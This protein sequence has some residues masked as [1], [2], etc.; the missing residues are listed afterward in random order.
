MEAL[1]S[2]V[3]LLPRRVRRHDKLMYLTVALAMQLQNLLEQSVGMLQILNRVSRLR[4]PPCLKVKDLISFLVQAIC[5]VVLQSNVAG[6]LHN[7]T[8]CQLGASFEVVLL[9]VSFAQEHLDVQITRLLGQA[10]LVQLNRLIES[11]LKRQDMSLV[12]QSIQAN[13]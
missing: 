5:Q 7:Q 1:M 10:D 8:L 6:V 4:Y 11:I 12:Q 9:K 3:D 13:L 2:K